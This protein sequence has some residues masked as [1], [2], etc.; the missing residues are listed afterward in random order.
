MK[1]LATSD[2]HGFVPPLE[3]CDVLVVAGDITKNGHM[4]EAEEFLEW[5]EKN[6]E[7]YKHAIIIAG[8]HDWVFRDTHVMHELFNSDKIHYLYNEEIIIDGIKFWGSPYTPE[9]EGW[10]FMKSDQDLGREVWSLI[11]DNVDVLITHGGPYGE[12]DYCNGRNV[13]SSSLRHRLCFISPDVHIFGHIHEGYGEV[14]WGFSKIRMY[15]VAYCDK[16]YIPGQPPKVI[17]I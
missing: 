17:E 4:S 15:N 16:H 13:G 2:L 1:L 12:L 9:F 11:P 10:A 3:P 7:F 8:N 5:L 14:E 6:T